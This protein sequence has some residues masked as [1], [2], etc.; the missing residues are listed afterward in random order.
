MRRF[1]NKKNARCTNYFGEGAVT[2]AAYITQSQASLGLDEVQMARLCK[3]SL[4]TLLR[5]KGGKSEPHPWAFESIE[6]VI[7]DAAGSMS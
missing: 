5:W 3:V 1:V 2:F 6:A 4:R 7:S